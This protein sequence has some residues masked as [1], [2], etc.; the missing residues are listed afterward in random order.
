MQ[1]FVIGSVSK[2]IVHAVKCPV[3]IIK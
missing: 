2:K 3:M 1:E